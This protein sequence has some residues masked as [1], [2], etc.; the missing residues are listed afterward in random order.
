MIDIKPGEESYYL[1]AITEPHSEEME[2]SE[3]RFVNW[4][5]HF[6]MQGLKNDKFERAHI[7]GHISGKELVE[8][9]KKIQPEIVIPI[10][11][12]FPEEFKKMHKKVLLVEKNQQYEL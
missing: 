3:E 12:E 5:K 2:I 9:I 10:H 1:R 6:N 8:F 11:T 4:I 7:S